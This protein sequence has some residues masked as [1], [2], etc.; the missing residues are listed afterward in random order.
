[1]LTTQG[2]NPLEK[3]KV[4]GKQVTKSYDKEMKGYIFTMG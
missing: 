1:V 3:C 2:K 4:D